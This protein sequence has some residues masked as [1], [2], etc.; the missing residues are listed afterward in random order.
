M[1]A[2]NGQP[3]LPKLY[4]WKEDR[5]MPDAMLWIAADQELYFNWNNSNL[6]TAWWQVVRKW[7]EVKVRPFYLLPGTPV[8]SEA[9]NHA[10]QFL[11]CYH[12]T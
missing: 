11:L 9:G 4:R 1:E 7:P 8:Q 10:N 5:G 2:G 3:D 6:L 12:Q